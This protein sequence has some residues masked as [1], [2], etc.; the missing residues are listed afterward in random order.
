MDR[1][2]ILTAITRSFRS[3]KDDFSTYGEKGKEMQRVGT[4]AGQ[5]SDEQ[6]RSGRIGRKR[7]TKA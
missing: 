1:S 4:K 5:G 3:F 7:Q 2:R 6:G